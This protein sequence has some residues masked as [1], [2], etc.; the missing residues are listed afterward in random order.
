MSF[1]VEFSIKAFRDGRTE[2]ESSVKLPGALN[3]QGRELALSSWYKMQL[4]ML[5]VMKM[6]EAADADDQ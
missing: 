4:D 3:E 6:R 1:A 5:A 2:Y